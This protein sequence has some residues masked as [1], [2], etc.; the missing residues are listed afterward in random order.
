LG[1][2]NQLVS[3]ITGKSRQLGGVLAE[4]PE[5]FRFAYTGHRSPVFLPGMDPNDAS[6]LTPIPANLPARV[7]FDSEPVATPAQPL[8]A[9]NST[10]TMS[11]SE[12]SKTVAKT[13][14][15]PA[16]VSAAI[17]L[18]PPEC[19]HPQARLTILRMNE[20]IKDEIQVEGS[21]NIENFDYYKFEY[22]RENV[23]DEWHWVA[24]FQEPVEEGV[25]GTWE[26][27]QLPDG[28]YT[29]RLVVVDV[30]GNYPFD[31]CEVQVHIE[32]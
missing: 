26:V 13:E 30:Q 7:G 25:L 3:T 5:E 17:P 29:F 27:S 12:Q 31:P 28:P 24:S 14:S 18:Q 8:G 6:Y 1:T 19:P 22:K 2:A 11:A 20:V 32:H 4:A 21:A 15:S 16:P 10:P 23:D 9:R